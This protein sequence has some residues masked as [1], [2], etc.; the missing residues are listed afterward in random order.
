MLSLSF[1]EFSENRH[2]YAKKR[3]FLIKIFFGP[4]SDEISNENFL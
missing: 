2:E 4:K 1:L 3:I